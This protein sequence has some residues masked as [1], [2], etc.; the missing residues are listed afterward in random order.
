MGIIADIEEIGTLHYELELADGLFEHEFNH[1]FCGVSDQ[2]PTP[3]PEEASDWKTLSL[4]D[5]GATVAANLA[6]F[7]MWFPLILQQLEK[8]LRQYV[9]QFLTKQA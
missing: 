2:Q 6:T 3:D 7:T 9:Q 4:D 5:A 8:P 1:V